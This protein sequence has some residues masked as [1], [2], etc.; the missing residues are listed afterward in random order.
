MR[1]LRRRLLLGARSERLEVASG[2]VPS[3]PSAV[4]VKAAATRDVETLMWKRLGSD[5][6]QQSAAAA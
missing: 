1:T 3:V 6:L 5:R 4:R 2:R